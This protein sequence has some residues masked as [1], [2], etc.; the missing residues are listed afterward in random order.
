MFRPGQEIARGPADIPDMWAS[1]S[2]HAQRLQTARTPPAPACIDKAEPIADAIG[3]ISAVHTR[4]SRDK[5]A[6]ELDGV[7]LSEPP[8][9]LAL[10]YHGPIIRDMALFVQPLLWGTGRACPW[11]SA[12]FP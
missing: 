3:Q 10:R 12:R 8:M 7:R 1:A 9:D 11:V 6:D 4:V 2:Q 5:L